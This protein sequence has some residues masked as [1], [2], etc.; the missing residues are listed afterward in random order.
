MP[1]YRG[2]YLTTIFRN[3]QDGYTIFVLKTQNEVNRVIK[4]AGE[5]PAYPVGI[6]LEVIAEKDTKSDLMLIQDIC[7]ST[8]G[9][10]PSEIKSY[11]ISM[12]VPV[13][14]AIDYSR[15]GEDFFQLLQN[16]S[17]R[18]SFV[19]DIPYGND[20][21]RKIRQPIEERMLRQFIKKLV[22]ASGAPKYNAV[23]AYCEGSAGVSM[24]MLVSNPY[25]ICERM[26]GMSFFDADK[27]AAVYSKND[28]PNRIEGMVIHIMKDVEK[29]G[30]TASDINNVVDK[31]VAMAFQIGERQA[32]TVTEVENALES[33]LFFDSESKIVSFESTYMMEKMTVLA[34]REMRKHTVTLFNDD[35]LKAAIDTIEKALGINYATAQKRAFNLLRHTGVSILTGGPGTGKTT[36]VNG[37]IRA[38]RSK[39]PD[40]T[41]VLCAPTGR[42]AQRMKETTGLEAST[43]HRLLGIGKK[44]VGEVK[45]N[46]N[47]IICDES[48]MLDAEMIAY[49][50]MSVPSDSLILLVGDVDQL[51]SVGAGDVL[52]DLINSHKLPCCR[53]D[54]VYRQSGES[55]IVV[56]ANL[57]NDGKEDL[58][59]D[60]TFIV[61]TYDQDEELMKS[62][63]DVFMKDQNTQLLCPSH[64]GR[65]GIQSMNKEIQ[66]IINP[67]QHGEPSV[68]FGSTEFRLRDRV[69]M[70]QN[71]YESGYF[72]GDMGIIKQI[73]AT[74]VTVM[75]ENKEITVR[76]HDLGDMA[77]SYCISIHKS[78][79]SE[80]ENVCIV[81]P[82]HPENML[83]R[84]L[85]YTGVTRAKK[86]CIILEQHGCISRCVNTIEKG[87]RT[88]R[89][90]KLICA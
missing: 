51:P 37:L 31:V 87:V 34:C 9:I 1:R 4:L 10:S 71:N 20:V 89:L 47:L 38:Y 85:L 72:N 8:E 76:K 23:H 74:S 84:N 3:E 36:T 11:L 50:V 78:Q 75:L 48:S 29:N 69:I 59:T 27:V 39:Y 63:L 57:I 6:P 70:T 30:S 67:K 80:F 13:R 53:L 82:E 25:H 56:N 40:H 15:R 28:R 12:G 65:A 61:R 32:P 22:G 83:K 24:S 2:C 41:I 79:G 44:Q 17:F 14:L 55:K 62:A 45:L 33:S 46:A 77:L 19:R 7:E 16:Y 90:K 73:T 88:T 68:R 52:N 81:L 35:E 5:I 21:Y 43:I 66:S 42:A 54:T 26:L 64:K 18:S 86:R 58:Q 60:S 49:L